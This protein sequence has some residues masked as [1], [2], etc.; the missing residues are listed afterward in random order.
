MS[1]VAH[2]LPMG[3][4][5]EN[6]FSDESSSPNLRIALQIMLIWQYLL[7]AASNLSGK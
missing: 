7:Q 2:Q 3:K 1:F 5:L 6:A 4:Q